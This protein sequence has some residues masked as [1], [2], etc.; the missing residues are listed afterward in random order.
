[1]GA[2]GNSSIVAT[3]G[4]NQNLFTPRQLAE[5]IKQHLQYSEGKPVI[6]VACQTGKADNSFAQKLAN[7]LKVP[8]RGATENISAVIGE[9]LNEGKYV[10][11]KP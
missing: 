6:L 4:P 11:I 7:E 10:T 9:G 5:L 1:M 8:V 3:N 2:H